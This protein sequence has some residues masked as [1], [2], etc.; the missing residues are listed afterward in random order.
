MNASITINKACYQRVLF[1]GLFL[2]L[3]S[4][5]LFA[6]I[7]YGGDGCPAGTAQIQPTSDGGWK[8][9][10]NSYKVSVTTTNAERRSCNVAISYDVPKGYSASFGEI[11]IS[12][13]YDLKKNIS[14]VVSAEAFFSGATAP[15]NN[16]TFNGES[17]GPLVLQFTPPALWTSCGASTILRMNTSLNVRATKQGQGASQILVDDILIAKPVLRRCS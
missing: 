4:S 12:G 17:A 8:V 16:S 2:A 5:H 14:A 11:K 1:I 15:Q 3:L 7:T 9:H 10:L 6:D 13:T